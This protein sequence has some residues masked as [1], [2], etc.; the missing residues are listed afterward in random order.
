MGVKYYGFFLILGLKIVIR[1]YDTDLVPLGLYLKRSL[2]QVFVRFL[3]A[4][5]RFINLTGIF[6]LVRWV[7]GLIIN[8]F[9]KVRW[10]VQVY[11]LYK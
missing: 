5:D 3:L 9:L 6:D 2:L 11:I 4:K 8:L 7:F 10:I 1:A